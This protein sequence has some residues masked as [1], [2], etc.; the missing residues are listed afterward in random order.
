MFTL[1]RR[2]LTLLVVAIAAVLLMLS[3]T[4]QAKERASSLSAASYTPWSWSSSSKS[5]SSS[6]TDALTTTGPDAHITETVL[7]LGAHASG[8]TMYERL[9]A[10]NGTLY[11]VTKDKS[12]H[13]DLLHVLSQGKDRGT[14]ENIDPTD[15]VAACLYRWRNLPN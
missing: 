10:W 13:P 15:K 1:S 12:K 4:P 11:V 3:T 6:P 8:F 9:Y 14:G 7:P 2:Q 5:S